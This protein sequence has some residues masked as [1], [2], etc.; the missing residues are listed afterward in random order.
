MESKIIIIITFLSLMR[1]SVVNV[2]DLHNLSNY[3]AGCKTFV[4]IAFF[5]GSSRL[6][7]SGKTL[8]WGRIL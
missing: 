5:E 1:L 4:L 2:L 7:T 3:L 8:V 6:G